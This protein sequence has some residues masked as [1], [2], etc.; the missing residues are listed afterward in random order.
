M[1]HM[2]FEVLVRPTELSFQVC[3]ELAELLTTQGRE[4]AAIARLQ[5]MAAPLCMEILAIVLNTLPG[6]AGL[7]A[8][9]SGRE[10]GAN[11]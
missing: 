10:S 3:D 8:N 6:G 1:R 2:L 5:Q 11:A 7:G 4:E 9:R